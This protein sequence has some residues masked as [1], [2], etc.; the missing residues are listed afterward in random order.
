MFPH[1]D[2]IRWRVLLALALSII[3]GMRFRQDLADHARSNRLRIG[4]LANLTHAVPLVGIHE[5]Y[6]ARVLGS[7]VQVNGQ[8]L[9]AGNDLV[10]SLAAGEIDAA[11]MGPGPALISESAGVPLIPLAGAAY[12][13]SVLVRKH[14]SLVARLQDLAGKRVTV[15]KYGNTQDV[16]LRSLL[17][18]VGVKDRA[19]GGTAD[20]LQ[21]DGADAVAML[22]SGQ[23]DGAMFPEPWA[24]RAVVDAKAEVV[25]D[26]RQIW[27]G[28]Y[29]SALLLVSRRYAQKYPERVR[30]L[31]TAHTDLLKE[32]VAHPE[33]AL[34][35]TNTALSKHTHKMMRDQVIRQSFARMRLDARLNVADLQRFQDA[36][37]RLGYLRRTVNVPTWLEGSAPYVKR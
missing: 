14:G 29:P 27:E 21:A 12:G 3:A 9:G 34:E 7:D 13:G 1:S 19:R 33:E 35:R 31:A 25:L 28:E 26:A 5:G 18:D 17:G 11:Y 20:I 22:R 6:F 16:L 8:I 24:S 2:L 4:Y 32:L 36:M 30:L 23:V 15:P 37:L 10:T